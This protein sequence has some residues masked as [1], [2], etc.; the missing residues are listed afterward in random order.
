[1]AV[2]GT[3]PEAIKVA[4]VVQAM[5]QSGHLDPVVVVTG[6]HREMLDQV[7]SLFG[8]TP[9]HD[10]DI[11]SSRQSL[12]DITTRTLQGLA[13][14]MDRERPE[15]VLVQGDTTTCFAAALSAFYHRVP[16]VHVEAGLRT[17][18]PYNPFPEEVNRRLTTQ[19]ASL[20]LAP[21]STSREN[22]IASGVPAAAIVTTGNTVIDA[23]LEVVARDAPFA[24]PELK[25]MDGR[26]CVLITSHR[27]ESW[28]EPMRNSGNAIRRLAQTFSDV[29][30]ILPVHL[31]PVV[32]D[33]LLPLLSDV[34]NVLITEPLDYGD[35][36]R[37]MSMSEV[38]L[39]D[40]GGVQ[41]EAPSL[42]K[43]VL[44]MRETT[45]RPEA[46]TAGTVRLVGTDEQSIVDEVTR[47]LT[48]PQA[49][50]RM[51]QAVNPYGDGHAAARSVAAMEHFFGHAPRPEEF[52][53]AGATPGR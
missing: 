23:L 46:V 39:T 43:P 15:L 16:V 6:Q 2:Y 33:V 9:H 48:D 7:N 4:P 34:P 36:S 19:L 51:A 8:I 24:V 52:D 3:R 35:F 18:N 27:R 38:V 47:L 1:M 45:E 41:E 5:Q 21:T 29:L 20:H 10:L 11:I 53:P 44:V 37:C 13:P 14:L 50:A 22:L 17:D 25:R 30:F 42:G 40:S 26:R 32:R 28:G 12:E 49:H 31:N